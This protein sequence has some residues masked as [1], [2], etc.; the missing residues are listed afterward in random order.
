MSHALTSSQKLP[1]E[2][3]TRVTSKYSLL[4]KSPTHFPK[5]CGLSRVHSHQTERHLESN[6]TIDANEYLNYKHLTRDFVAMDGADFAG[7]SLGHMKCRKNSGPSVAC[8]L[9]FKKFSGII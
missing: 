2:I 5:A 9:T 4:R 3:C 1:G 7:R 6:K 8:G